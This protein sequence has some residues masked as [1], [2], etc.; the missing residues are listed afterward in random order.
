MTSQIEQNSVETVSDKIKKNPVDE[1]ICL[2]I[3]IYAL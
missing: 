2:A 3:K 1:L